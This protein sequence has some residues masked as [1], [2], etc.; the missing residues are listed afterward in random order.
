[1][2]KIAIL[3]VMMFAVALWFG[4]TASAHSGGD[5]HF[6]HV[7][8]ENDTLCTSVDDSDIDEV[9]ATGTADEI[10]VIVTFHDPIDDDEGPAEPEEGPGNKRMVKY[11]LHIDHHGP[12][13]DDGPYP[14]PHDFVPDPG[15]C[16]TS[17][18][19]GVMYR[20]HKNGTG[21]VYGPGTVVDDEDTI[22]FTVAYEDLFNPGDP[23]GP[24]NIPSNSDDIPASR[25]VDDGDTVHLWVDVQQKQ[26]CDRAPFTDDSNGCAKPEFASEV[27]TIVL[28]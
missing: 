7:D 15:D 19:T 4:S 28:D 18:D 21:R 12:E 20:L 10:E 17:S 13:L 8:I 22:T 1:M 24:D 25:H 6:H 26:I 14:G 3:F 5:N 16:E 23:D 9:T 2:K 27:I 11:R